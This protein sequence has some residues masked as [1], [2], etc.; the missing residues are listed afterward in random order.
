MMKAVLS[1]RGDDLID[2]AKAD[3]WQQ[4]REAF[5]G[6]PGAF[7]VTGPIRFHNF[8]SHHLSVIFDRAC[9]LADGS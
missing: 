8:V 7:I 5:H 3:L 2:L 1:G 6:R 9:S 4:W